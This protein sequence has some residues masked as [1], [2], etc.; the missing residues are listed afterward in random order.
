MN[1]VLVFFLI[2]AFALTFANENNSDELQ[3]PCEK[4]A[5]AR[6]CAI[7]HILHVAA[8][9][10]DAIV[11]GERGN[12]ADLDMEKRKSA[13]VRFGKRKSAFVRFGRSGEDDL[14]D[15]EKR[16]SAFVRFGRSAD[17][18]SGSAYVRFG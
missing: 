12:D 16:K 1:S 2:S 6:L 3:N 5:N 15:M 14:H 8:E 7:G 13:F 9:E 10:I 17:Q 18:R 11:A 4:S